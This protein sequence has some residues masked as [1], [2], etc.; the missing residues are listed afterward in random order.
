MKTQVEVVSLPVEAVL[1]IAC[2]IAS[3]TDLFAFLEALRPHNLL[4][5]LE[6]LWQLGLT[7]DHSELWPELTIS[8]SDPPEYTASVKEIIKYYP[9]IYIIDMHDLEWI[10][11][12]VSSTTL[13]EW[14]FT[15]ALPTDEF[16]SSWSQFR[17]SR[18]YITTNTRIG[19]RAHSV[20][21]GFQSALPNLHYLQSLEVRGAIQSIDAI[22]AFAATSSYL[23]DL[24][25]ADAWSTITTVVT[26]RM[27][28]DLLQW[29]RRQRVQAFGFSNWAWNVNDVAL[30]N[31]FYDAIFNWSTLDK[32]VCTSVD[33][34]DVDFS[35]KA[36]NLS[37]LSLGW[38]EL[39]SDQVFAIANQLVGSKMT[40]FSLSGYYDA[41]VDGVAHLF[42]KLPETSIQAFELSA[43]RFEMS[44]W[45][46]LATL[47]SKFRV[48]NL[49]M[50]SQA[51]PDG[52]A[53]L[54][55]QA[56]RDNNTIR[57]LDVT[58]CNFDVQGIASLIESGTHPERGALL[59]S[60]KY[61]NYTFTTIELA[62]LRSLATERGIANIKDTMW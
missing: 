9:L 35:N 29:F 33:L 54:I 5:P 62:A 60:I 42:E 53:Q 30:K 58:N 27:L 48:Q 7:F 23:I 8:S 34:S 57:E 24:K 21:E 17:I 19:D 46:R 47:L 28:R 61:S 12:Y 22:L 1:N 6:H 11:N 25:F 40:H 26:P 4:G 20:P 39:H 10:S 45:G 50:K 3:P 44:T 38:C 13:Q 2:Y 31:S 32:L 15:T 52:A 43:C 14:Y 55:A 36:L 59:S 49:I 18:V 56:I 51:L 16:W 41:N 37:S